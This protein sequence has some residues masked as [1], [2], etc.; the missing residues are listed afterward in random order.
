MPSAAINSFAVA[1]LSDVQRTMAVSAVVRSSENVTRAIVM[2]DS[3]SLASSWASM[4]SRAALR[5]PSVNRQGSSETE[6]RRI[7]HPG[8]GTTLYKSA[9]MSSMRKTVEA[10]Y[11][12]GVF[13]PLARP[14]GIEEHRQVTLTV[15]IEDRPASIA[16]L[17]GC[18]PA[19]DAEEMRGIVERE[20]ER[21][22]LRE[23]Q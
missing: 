14:E 3:T 13:R 17:S 2:S 5:V 15:T 23:W 1:N 9:R 19:A 8:L 16:D 6:F 10:V 4:I 21:V 20:F 12:N 22:D 7:G 18:M 11:E